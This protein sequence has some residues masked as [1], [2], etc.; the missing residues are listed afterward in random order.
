M[1]SGNIPSSASP[2]IGWFFFTRLMQFRPR[3]WL[4]LGCAN[5]GPSLV[6]QSFGMQYCGTSP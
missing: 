4:P 6:R 2:L 1:T 5:S 3:S